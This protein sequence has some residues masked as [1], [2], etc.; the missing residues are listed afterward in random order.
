MFERS[1][2]GQENTAEF[3]GVDYVCYVEGG[4]G[5]TDRSADC[6]FWAT[7]IGRLRPDLKIKFRARGGK[8]QLE[9][10]ASSIIE[11][12]IGNIIVAM[13][14]D[15][16]RHDGTLIPHTR[17][18]YTFGYRWENDLFNEENILRTIKSMAL[19]S[20]E[21]HSDAEVFFRKIYKDLIRKLFWPCRSDHIAFHMQGSILPRQSPGQ[22]IKYDRALNMPIVDRSRVITICRDFKPNKKPY[23]KNK[24]SPLKNIENYCVG[25]IY[26]LMSVYIV[27]SVM[28]R[29]GNRPNQSPDHVRDV[30][31]GTF[32]DMV[33]TNDANE[34]IDHYKCITSNI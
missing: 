6:F 4:G 22:V 7:V 20:D 1:P 11:D 3:L 28:A 8:A 30:A 34:V 29:L 9:Q 14:S 15:Y 27:R 31:F 32:C 33:L 21:I 13:D 23:R 12:E 18:F 24:P 5:Q 25:H 19:S 10:I 26:F 2:K 16:D 17:I